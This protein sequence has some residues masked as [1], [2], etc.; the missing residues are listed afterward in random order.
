MTDLA[1]EFQVSEA[2]IRRDLSEVEQEGYLKR[3][4]GGVILDTSANH[5][6]EVSQRLNDQKEQKA[7]IGKAAADLVQDGEHIILDSGTT[8][9][10]IAKNLVNRS[11]ITVIT[12]DIN[13][14]A[15]LREAKGITVIVIGGILA[16]NSYMLNGMFALNTL[17]TLHV[18]KYFLGTSSI[19]AKYG[20]TNT[21]A[22]VVEVK[23][24]MI[25]VAQEIIITAD[26]TKI[27][28]VTLHEVAPI[29]SIHK[30]ITGIEA[31]E[32]QLKGFR[33]MGI[34]VIQV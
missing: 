13:V 3:T 16:P 10:Y 20:S 24:A 26:D 11:N 2:T 19:H 27:G 7:R 23:K 9:L 29:T 31:S 6:P 18:Q 30:F 4:H 25:E 12:N 28:K 22:D 34:T 14:A 21:N 32:V 33:D 17:K 5:E 1:S 8:T 15:E